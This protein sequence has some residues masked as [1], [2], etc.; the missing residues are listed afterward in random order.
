MNFRVIGTFILVMSIFIS[1]LTAA[2]FNE[3]EFSN[4]LMELHKNI[5]KAFDYSEDNEIYNCLYGSITGDELDTQFFEFLKTI[6][7][8]EA[9]G[10]RN[11]VQRIAY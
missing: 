9:L 10:Y 11:Y 1:G 3:E 2:D 6:R 4:Y 7:Y 8:F 5:Y